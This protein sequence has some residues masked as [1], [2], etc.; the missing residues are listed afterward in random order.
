MKNS[1]NAD[2]S[3]YL[4]SSNKELRSHLLQATQKPLVDVEAN[5]WVSDSQPVDHD[6]SGGCISDIPQIRYLHYDS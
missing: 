1:L 2:L 3:Q 5:Q 6:S 4:N